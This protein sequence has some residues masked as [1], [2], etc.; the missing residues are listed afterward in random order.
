[1]DT[2]HAP[3][4]YLLVTVRRVPPIADSFFFL[5]ERCLFVCILRLDPGSLIAQSLA[6]PLA[7]DCLSIPDVLWVGVIELHGRGRAGG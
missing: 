4:R 1:M 7:D 5:L 2:G 3:T 6:L